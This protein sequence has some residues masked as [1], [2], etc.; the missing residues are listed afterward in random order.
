MPGQLGLRSASVLV[1]RVLDIGPSEAPVD[2]EKIGTGLKVR[3]GH[4][5]L[6]A[7]EGE[8]SSP[9]PMDEGPEQHAGTA[10]VLLETQMHTTDNML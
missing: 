4:S 1:Q 10:C 6:K 2:Q 7:G 5:R 8:T 3:T 9:E